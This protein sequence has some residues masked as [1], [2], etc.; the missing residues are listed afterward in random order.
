MP[1]FFA[2]LLAVFALAAIFPVCGF[3]D[4]ELLD[5]E[6]WNAKFQA[7]YIW[8]HKNAFNAA[9][10]GANSLSPDTEKSYSFTST[11]AF[12]FRPWTGGEIYFDAEA[13]QGVPLSNL[14]GLGGVTNGEIA[15][16]TGP[17]LSLYR[18][19]LF[20]RQTWDMG[21]V[22]EAVESDANQLAGS[23]AKR[24][25][26]V[27]AGNLS[28]TDIFDNNAYSDDPRT[29]F[30]NGALMTYGAYDYAADARGYTWGMALE[31]YYDEWAV[32]FG[33]FTQ[34]EEPNGLPLDSAIFRHY[35]DQIEVEHAHEWFGQPGK[36][37]FLAFHNHAKMSRYQDALNYA[38]A[39]GGT[40]DLN[41][42]RYGDQSKIGFGVSLE[43]A[44]SDNIG[45]FARGSWANGQTETYA[46]TEIDNSLS[47]GLLIKGNAWRRGQD[48]IGIAFVRNG[49]S[50][51]HRNY[52]A[53]GGLG[54]FIGDGQLNYR[55]EDIFETFYSLSVLNHNQI[56]LDWQHIVNPAY[57]ADRGPVEVFS[58]R[59]HTEF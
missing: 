59:L 32:R 44:L 53:A 51:E 13:S 8:Q 3:A 35:G 39:N 18:A 24:R 58:M 23:V 9:Y 7:T 45:L 14:T 5:A 49:L 25:F 28:A 43:Q 41:A 29:K 11:A 20:L 30:F 38:A 19:R 26:V 31:W 50:S 36:L 16:T 46:F 6:N 54:F 21:D 1:R 12:G 2:H 56:S 47:G 27:T 34:P 4:T 10:S 17:N 55:P 37:R 15:R 33:H 57:N 48:N 42:V 52:L 22:R 40:P